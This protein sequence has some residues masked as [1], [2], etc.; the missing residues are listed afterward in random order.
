MI[1]SSNCFTLDAEY[2][3]PDAGY[4]MPSG[5]PAAARF[6]LIFQSR[7]KVFAVL[8]C[9]FLV[10]AGWSQ[11]NRFNV[12]GYYSGKHDAAHISFVHEA[13]NWF[14][15]MGEKYHFKYDSTNNWDNLN[16]EF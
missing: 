4:W 8:V 1:Q 16:T 13:N 7:K 6:R 11:K 15:K 5:W 9:C 10:L 12:I 2:R 14:F 3:M